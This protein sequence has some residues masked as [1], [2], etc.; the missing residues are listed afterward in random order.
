MAGKGGVPDRGQA[1]LAIAALAIE[2]QQL[3]KG[4]QSR[5]VAGVIGGVTQ[6]VEHH[7]GVGHRWKD[8]SKAIFAVEALG[9][10]GDGFV[11]RTP[12]RIGRK[13]RLGDPQ[14]AV[15]HPEGYGERRG[16]R[17]ADPIPHRFRRL[18]KKL[19]DGDAE[20]VEGPRAQGHQD[21][22]R[23]ENRA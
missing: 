3:A 16:G 19:A 20:R 17:T 14:Q 18:Q 22:Q 11:D 5:R 15:E 23:H 8:A 12:P 7:R 1:G 4:G 10:K 13:K 21:E 9:D 2:Y 6:T